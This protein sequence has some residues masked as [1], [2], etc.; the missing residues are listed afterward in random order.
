MVMTPEDVEAETAERAAIR[1]CDGGMDRDTA[2]FMA[3]RDMRR[4]AERAG[5]PACPRCGNNG[6]ADVPQGWVPHRG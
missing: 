2:E 3:R 4:I 6:Q 1:K 5:W